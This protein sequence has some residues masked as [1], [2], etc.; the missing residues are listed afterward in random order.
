MLKTENNYRII[1]LLGFLLLAITSCDPSKKYEKQE[2]E[3]IQ[4]F[5]LE[6]PE[7][8]FTLKQ[9]GLYYLDVEVGAGEPAL[10]HDTA[11]V[12]YTGMFLNG[13]E[14]DT[15]LDDNDTLIFP[16]NEG[17]V[18]PGVDEGVSYMKAGGKSMLVVP[19]YLGYGNSGYYFPSYTP[20]WFEIELVRI[21]P[22][23]G[24]K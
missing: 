12:M 4:D 22:A 21:A 24:R 5:I 7:L 13:L 23:S 19:S 9:S 8:D 1:C 14:F 10:T 11:Y 17:G 6:H 20:I 2:E 18:I 16:I 3:K 15:N